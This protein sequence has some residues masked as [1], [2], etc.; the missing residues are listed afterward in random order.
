M[1]LKG[2]TILTLISILERLSYY[3]VR[4]ILVLYLTDPNFL[5]LSSETTIQFY[6]FWTT[7]L[8]LVAIPFSLITDK[9]LGQKRSI[10]VGGI[11]SLIGYLLLII[12]NQTI[13]ILSVILILA[14]TSLVKPSTTILIG[15]QFKK[16]NK[17]RTLAYMIFFMGINIGAF[18]G[19]T[20]IG[21]VGEIYGW[22]YGFIIAALSTLSYL[23]ITYLFEQDVKEIETNELIKNEFKISIKKTTLIVLLLVLIHVVFWKNHEIE[24]SEIILNL[25]SSEK[26]TLFG[27]EILNS[28]IQAF[29]SLWTILLTF[30]LFI[31]WYIKG[32]T[33]VFKTITISIVILIFA[34]IGSQ[35][36]NHF[37][38][39]DLLEWSLVLLALYAFAEVLI[40]P[41]LTSYITR[42][43][44]IDY[45]NTIYSVFILLTYILGSGF[46]YL[47][48]TEFQLYITLSTLVLT[49]IG[50]ILFTQQIGKLTCELK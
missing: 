5:N 18:I 25:S 7:A 32:V 9:Y 44:H 47:L 38:P 14:G 1:K 20:T 42:I 36:L 40:S 33:N 24:T 27:Y 6:G 46:V 4:A 37:Q 19:V 48:Q 41:I 35:I 31:Y 2:T 45:S 3:G 30:I 43:S 17:N 50:I 23:I 39:T 21:Y 26:R 12:Q 8:V 13:I 15:R 28:M 49:L 22:K 16:E 29:A 11:L 34:I 10:I